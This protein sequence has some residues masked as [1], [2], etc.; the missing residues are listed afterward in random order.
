MGF[1]KIIKNKMEKY[2][3]ELIAGNSLDKIIL[4]DQTLNKLTKATI[5][6]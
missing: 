2:Q 4:L 3:N 5:Y 6:I 1:L